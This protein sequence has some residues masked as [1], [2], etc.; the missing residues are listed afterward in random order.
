MSPLSRVE[1][2][3]LTVSSVLDATNFTDVNRVFGAGAY[4]SQPLPA[5]GQLTQAG[6]PRQLQIGAR[7]R[8]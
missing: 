2:F 6:P 3:Q 7:F 5:F 4:P 1:L 8:Y